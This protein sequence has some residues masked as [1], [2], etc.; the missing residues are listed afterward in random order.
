MNGDHGPVRVS[1]Q[2]A[3]EAPALPGEEDFRTWAGLAL[4][5]SGI[6]L[7]SRSCVTIRIV[8]EHESQALNTSFRNVPKPTNVLAFPAG[9]VNPAVVDD[10]EEL[11]DLIICAAVVLEEAREQEKDV[12]AH[13]A[14]MTVHGC[15]HLAGYDHADD[16]QA[17]EMEA[18]EVQIMAG[19]GFPNP[20]SRNNE[21]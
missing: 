4:I 19:L 17:T 5:S 1:L 12:A 9:P 8:D 13:F 11:G 15:L 10:D 18:L 16:A 14:H 2:I 21:R 3:T 20:Y 7:T 6:P